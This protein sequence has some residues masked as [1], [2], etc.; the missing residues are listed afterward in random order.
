MNASK[1]IVLTSVLSV[2]L[3]GTTCAFPSENLGAAFVRNFRGDVS[4]KLAE[5]LSQEAIPL[6]NKLIKKNGI[7]D[8]RCV[9]LVKFREVG[10]K[11]W[12]ARAFLKDSDD[13]MGMVNVRL[14]LV[15]DYISVHVDWD[16]FV[17]LDND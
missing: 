7:E 16:S 17:I 9:R 10:D 11:I 2:L 4:E 15:D 5:L 14:E 1:L 13:G 3:A 6:I 8:V 12:E